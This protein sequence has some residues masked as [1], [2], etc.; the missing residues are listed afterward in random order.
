MFGFDSAAEQQMWLFRCSEAPYVTSGNYRHI[1]LKYWPLLVT[2]TGGK[3][4]DL[5]LASHLEYISKKDRPFL[6][7]HRPPDRL[8][9]HAK[10]PRK[11][12]QI[13]LL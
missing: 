4:I 13:L 9:S 8:R 10:K 1:L 6:K 2:K 7:D 3:H 12:S 11:S 5:L